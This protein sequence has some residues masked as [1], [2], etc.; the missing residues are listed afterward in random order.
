MPVR[1]ALHF[2]VKDDETFGTVFPVD[3]DQ[4]VHEAGFDVRVVVR[5]Y[6]PLLFV[7]K[8]D[9][10]QVK[11]LCETGLEE[12]EEEFEHFLD[13]VFPEAV[14]VFTGALKDDSF[15]GQVNAEGPG[16]QFGP[17]RNQ[18]HGVIFAQITNNIGFYVA[19]LKKMT[20]FKFRAPDHEY[21]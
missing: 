11:M 7:Q 17:C 15:T 1:T 16:Q 3:F 8:F 14:V 2:D 4:F 19:G 21:I 9:V 18:A 5:K 20:K 13:Q 12:P 10:A 6:F